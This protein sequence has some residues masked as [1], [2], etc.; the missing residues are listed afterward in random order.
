MKWQIELEDDQPGLHVAGVRPRDVG[1]AA[2]PA[3]GVHQQGRTNRTH[4]H[5]GRFYVPDTGIAIAHRTDCQADCLRD[6]FVLDVLKDNLRSPAVSFG[7]PLGSFDIRR[8]IFTVNVS[9]SCV[10]YSR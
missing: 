10:A 4:V 2:S 9:G 7:L 8:F 1:S 5:C 3:I 6:A